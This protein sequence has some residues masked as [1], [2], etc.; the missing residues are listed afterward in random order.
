MA[1]DAVKSKLVD[2]TQVP[3]IVDSQTAIANA[4]DATTAISQLNLALAALRAHGL[5]KE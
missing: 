5:I 1:V 3:Q 2:S 4:T